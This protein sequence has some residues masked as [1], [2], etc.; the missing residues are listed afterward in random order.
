MPG[1]WEETREVRTGVRSAEV[2]GRVVGDEREE[3]ADRSPVDVDDG[4]APAGRDLDGAA[5][6]RRN[7]DAAG[8][9][10]VGHEGQLI[11]PNRDARW[12]FVQLGDP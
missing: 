9:L 5:L 1:S 10:Q 2:F 4:E 7:D 8:E 11:T 3:V 6:A 12:W